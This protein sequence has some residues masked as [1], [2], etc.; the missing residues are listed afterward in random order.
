M[1]LLTACGAPEG[2]LSALEWSRPGG[3]VD[4]AGEPL[5]DHPPVLLRLGWKAR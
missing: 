1:L 5:S 3:F 2:E 4:E